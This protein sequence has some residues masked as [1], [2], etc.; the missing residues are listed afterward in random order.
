MILTSDQ[1]HIPIV[2]GSD[3]VLLDGIPL[4]TDVV[5]WSTLRGGSATMFEPPCT[6][7]HQVRRVVV[8][9]DFIGSDA[10]GVNM[11][12]LLEPLTCDTHRAIDS[13][14]G[15]RASRGPIA[16]VLQLHSAETY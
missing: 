12:V 3:L 1:S 4:I 9:A 2:L 8:S 16:E 14:K 5:S 11:S 15:P 13:K 10:A 6:P 7:V